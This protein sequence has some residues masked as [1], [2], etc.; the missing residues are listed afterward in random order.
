[1]PAEPRGRLRVL[2]VEDEAWQV[3]GTVTTVLEIELGADVTVVGSAYEARMA[4]R[5]GPFDVIVLDVMMDPRKALRLR[6]TSL[7]LAKQVRDGSLG[8]N[9]TTPIVLATGV[10]DLPMTVQR[11]GGALEQTRVGEEAR[12]LLGEDLAY[13]SKPYTGGQLA[14]KIREV[15]RSREQDDRGA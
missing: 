5:R 7:W 6:E 15:L 2:Y 9:R 1:M 12:R 13:L 8:R 11:E 10:W 14:S 4:L 3:E